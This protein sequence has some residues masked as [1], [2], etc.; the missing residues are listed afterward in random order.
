MKSCLKKTDVFDITRSGDLIRAAS[1][2]SRFH[3]ATSSSRE[4]P[5]GT[6]ACWSVHRRLLGVEKGKLAISR[7]LQLF[8]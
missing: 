3:G 7:Q 1:N 6:S 4:E 2:T 5:R 8:I